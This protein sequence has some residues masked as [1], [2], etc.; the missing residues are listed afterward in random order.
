MHPLGANR[1][2]ELVARVEREVAGVAGEVRVGDA[3]VAR[4]TCVSCGV[5]VYTNALGPETLPEPSTARTR[6]R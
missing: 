6:Y 1:A 2:Y 5:S 3:R 4:G